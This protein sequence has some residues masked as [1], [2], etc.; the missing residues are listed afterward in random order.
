MPRTLLLV[1]LSASLPSTLTAAAPRLVFDRA[2]LPALREATLS[3][4]YAAVW[5]AILSRAEAQAEPGNPA[6]LDSADPFQAR[7]RSEHMPQDRYEALLAH[8]IGRTLTECME[9]LGFAYQISGRHDLGRHAADFL[10]A[11]ATGYPCTNPV[12]AKGFA[13]GRGDIMHGLALG[14]DWVGELLTDEQRNEV[15]AVCRGYVELFCDE[16]EDPGKWWYRVHN[17]NGVNGGA[18]GCL[19]LSLGT[20]YPDEYRAWVD[21][22]VHVV[23]CWLSAGF[24]RD[25]AYFEGV[26]YAEYG[27]SHTVLFAEALRQ[28]DLGHDLF[29]HPLF[30]EL[31]TFYAQ[32][33]LPGERVC[34][35]RN[36]ANYAGLGAVP[37]ALAKALDSGLYRWI[38]DR[39]GADSG[40]R[41]ILWRNEV[42]PTPPQDSGIPLSTHFRDRG[43]CVWRTGWD[44]ADVMLSIEAGPYHPTTHN[45]AD[46]GHFNLYGLGYRWA[47]DTGYANENAPTGRGQAAAHSCVLIGDEGQ[48]RSGAGLGTDGQVLIYRNSERLGYALCDNTAAYRANN[49]G[50][51]GVGVDFARRHCLFVYPRADAPAYTVILDDI[52]KDDQAHPFTWQMMI[53][54]GMRTE[55]DGGR[56]VL[57][58]GV[59]S[60]HAY[61]DSPLDSESGPDEGRGEAAFE[62]PIDRAGAY[63]VWARVRTRAEEKLKADSFYVSMDDGERI[64]WHMP[65]SGV[66]TW[67]RVTRSPSRE[68]VSF[69]LRPGQHR[70]VF[71]RREPAA[72]IDC[73]VVRPEDA[74][75]P[76]PDEAQADPLFR[77]AESGEITPPM[78]VVRVPEVATRLL[79]AIDAVT[80]VSLRRDVRE[81]L[82][83]HGPGRYPVLRADTAAVNP[84]FIAVLIPLAA[85][86][87]RPSVTFSAA[88]RGR[89]VRIAWPGHEDLITWPDDERLS[90][91][92]R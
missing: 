87:A 64:D 59:A 34:D 88:D 28:A 15:A 8:S 1:L 81:T 26:G 79:V 86:N 66:W 32:S 25:G 60:G 7:S 58:P 76:D 84:R 42:V 24:G 9:S 69:Q 91:S 16:F 44:Q 45:Q 33:I 72:E 13:G 10:Y 5:Q 30:A 52:R 41:R 89:Q 38:W 54:E 29:A 55:I 92:L 61:V 78:R 56:A 20:A 53:E 39:A 18:A 37:L 74:A 14:L 57:A 51:P 36:N 6:Y 50:M 65:A 62:I 3:P 80:P 35:A 85:A 4:E 22:A 63:V 77:E 11:V 47:V 71:G 46:K 49:R 83:Y 70:L 75:P 68:P 31:G 27:L 48:A 2:D 40:F 12:V 17:Y 19:A 43:L 90:P 21:Q 82:D 23:D 67:A 73:F